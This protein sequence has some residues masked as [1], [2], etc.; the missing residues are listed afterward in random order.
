M[1]ALA[2]TTALGIRN[3][4][5]AAHQLHEANQ[6][7]ARETDLPGWMAEMV[8]ALAD[9][10]ASA[11]ADELGVPADEWMALQAA[12]LRAQGVLLDD[13]RD[14][15]QRRRKFR[16]I[17][18][19]LRFR[20]ARLAEHQTVSEDRPVKDLAIWFERILPVSHTDKG[21]LFGVSERTWQRWSSESET[22][23]PT[24]AA[25]A[26]LRL[27]SRLINELRH[28]LTA[29]GALRWAQTRLADLDDRSPVE[30]FAVND[31]DAVR[32]VFALVAA[33][34]SGAAA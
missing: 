23:A 8:R 16:L 5:F 21:A 29:P 19:E 15:R 12:A 17:I 20:L 14:E 2:M 26:Q 11:T 24:G 4:E 33:A 34:R 30:A 1:P 32:R 9:D 13:D 3:P 6:R 7:L 22:A 31:A 27:L 10:I 25:A 28:T 18:E